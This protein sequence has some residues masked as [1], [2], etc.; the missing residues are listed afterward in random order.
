MMKTFCGSPCYCSP[1]CLCRV[2]YDGRLSDVW[3]LGVILYAMVTGEHPWNITNT[4]IMLR[5]ILKG[6]YTVPPFVSPQCKELITKMMQVNPRDRITVD[7]ILKHPWLKVAARCPHKKP[8]KPRKEILNLPPLNG[9]TLEE[10]SEASAQSSQRSDNGIISPFEDVENPGDDGSALPKLCIRSS[11]LQNVR[12]GKLSTEN[13]INGSRRR[14]V[15]QGG[16]G[17]GQLTASSRQR[18]AA[19]LLMQR[20]AKA[21]P[22]G[23]IPMMTITEDE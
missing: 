21:K 23:G 2:Q 9:L 5:Q 12:M 6:A 10:I 19:N 22:Q 18:S 8:V 20:G 13:S 15:P 11:S 17:G 3:S 4:S 7:E 1:E 14:L 16:G